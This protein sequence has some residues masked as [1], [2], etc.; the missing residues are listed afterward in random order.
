MIRRY[1][2]AGIMANGVVMERYEGT[3]KGGFLSPLVANVLL[4]E[5]EQEPEKRGLT[6]ARYAD[7][8]NVYTASERSAKDAVATLKQAVRTTPALRQGLQERGGTSVGAQVPGFRPPEAARG[9]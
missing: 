6:F 1:L 8:F 7:D 4:D 3:A 5:V 9:G 2:E